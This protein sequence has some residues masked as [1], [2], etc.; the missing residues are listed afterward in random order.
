MITK[1]ELST[2]EGKQA[3]I[4]ATVFSVN[5]TDCYQAN[6]TILNYSNLD[7]QQIKSESIVHMDH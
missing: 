5:D 2:T 6:H 4:I 7:D 3:K 1:E